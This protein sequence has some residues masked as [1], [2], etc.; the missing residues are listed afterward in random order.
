[1]NYN[2]AYGEAIKE[3]NDEQK[4]AVENIEGPVMVIAGPGTGKTQVMAARIGNILKKTDSQPGNILCLTYTD[5]ATIAMRKRLI[6]F[7]GP[8]AYNIHIYT[9]HAFC[10]S[11][12][13]DNLKYFGGYRE[14]QPLTE[15]E[16]IEVLEDMIDNLSKDHVLKRLTGDRYYERTRLDGLFSL[17]KKENWSPDFLINRVNQY[18]AELPFDERFLYKRNTPSKGKKKGDVKDHDVKKEVDKMELLKAGARL[19]IEYNQRLN[20]LQRYDYFDMITWVINAFDK[21]SNLL[22]DYQERFQYI[23]VDEYQDTNGAQNDLLYQLCNYWEAPNVFVVGDDDQSI[24]RFQGANT[25]NIL[26]FRAKYETDL[27]EIVLTK[28]YRSTQPILDSARAL[29]L[30]GEERLEAKF[31]HLIKKL[32]AKI[33]LKIGPLPKVTRYSNIEHEQADLVQ[34]LTKWHQEGRD[35]DKIAVIYRNHKQVEQVVKALQKKGV[36]FQLRRKINILDDFWIYRIVQVCRYISLEAENPY[37]GEH[38]LPE[39]MH[40]T[41]FKIHPHD[42]AK[43]ARYC[44]YKPEEEESS[45]RWLDVLHDD[46]M[47]FTL[48]LTDAKGIK[49]FCNNIDRW[50]KSYFN[51]T[52]QVQLD[53]ILTYGGILAEMLQSEEKAWMMQMLSTFF[54]LIK[55]ESRRKKFM[56]LNDIIST[57]DKM[58]RYS[59][60]LPIQRTFRREKGV[61]FITAHSSKGLEF[62]H[63]I[64]MGATTNQW[65]GKRKFHSTYSIPE[66]VMGTGEDNKLEDERRLFYVAMT[67]AKTRLDITFSQ[68]NEKQKKLQESRFLVELQAENVIQNTVDVN[69][70][71]GK[72]LDDKA[73]FEFGLAQLLGEGET[74]YGWID[75]TIIDEVLE[76]FRLSVTA[77][78]KYLTCPISFYFDNI[79]RVPSARTVHTGFGNAIHLTL[80]K[81]HNH[82]KNH[83]FYLDTKKVLQI[84]EEKMDHLHS[85]FSPLEY[86]DRMAYGKMILPRYIDEYKSEWPNVSHFEMEYNISQAV[87]EEI[88]IKGRLDRVEIRDNH[89]RVIDYKTGK[90]DRGKAKSKPPKSED[91]EGQD[92][93]RQMVFYK[94]LIDNDPKNTWIWDS[95]CFDFIQPDKK[96]DKFSIVDV[97]VNPEAEEKVKIQIKDTW[98]KIHN[99]EF[100]KGCGDE[101]CK[102]CKFIK[103]NEVMRVENDEDEAGDVEELGML[104]ESR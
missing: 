94:L 61:H 31:A 86:E 3:L 30:K 62:D 24:Y 1:M 64:I 102:W 96:T 51:D 78:N 65:E 35:L 81:M 100:E 28:N 12:I 76:K 27:K 7:I 95:G 90:V 18:L 57:L 98:T 71:E 42:I 41:F 80:E 63:V 85:H 92:Y 91:D 47:L 22:R 56:K 67:R 44:A 70:K 82:Y 29:I 16:K 25:E 88:P 60:S 101:N 4:I 10:N 34:K 13:Q 23:L 104:D 17:M 99:H 2:Q 77:L 36:P 97:D 21:N 38:L 58:I 45:K 75:H 15:L 55:E 46:K 37:S 74:H 53:N 93:W 87:C 8:T 33:E 72:A 32:T 52:V 54:D 40:Y 19:F 39:I 103:F 69:N 26:A 79:L 84:F 89:V 59:V 43:I 49:A 83:G 68:E 66:T 9:F 50:V 48:S 6:Q 20:K 11:I 5:A 73:M 14:L